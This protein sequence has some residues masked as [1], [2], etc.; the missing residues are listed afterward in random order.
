LEVQAKQRVVSRSPDIIIESFH[1][2][3]QRTLV[4]RPK[5][6][7]SRPAKK[8]VEEDYQIEGGDDEDCTALASQQNS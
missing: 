2:K 4:A 3:M 6:G 8:D 5:T 1:S 7:Q